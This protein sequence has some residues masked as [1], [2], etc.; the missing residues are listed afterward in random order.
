VGPPAATAPND[1][2]QALPPPRVDSL[3][4]LGYPPPK[5]SETKA[6]TPEAHENQVS[7][8]APPAVVTTPQPGVVQTSP[9]A[10]PRPAAQN[11]RCFFSKKSLKKIMIWCI[12]ALIIFFLI[13]FVFG[14]YNKYH[15][16]KATCN[17]QQS[18]LSSKVWGSSPCNS[19]AHIHEVIC[20]FNS[21]FCFSLVF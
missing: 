1:P 18:S 13:N 11:K 15:E 20:N 9:V 14:V 5:Y 12:V 2:T 7:A 4:A 16:K 10:P 17:K 3:G 8:L 19:S 6:N 21:S